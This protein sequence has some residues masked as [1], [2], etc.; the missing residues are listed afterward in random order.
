MSEAIR[1]TG[2]RG[3]REIPALEPLSIAVR[4]YAEPVNN[5][6]KPSQKNKHRDNYKRSNL[7]PSEH[8][9]VF[10]TETT[11]D[12]AQQLRFGCFQMRKAGQLV[13]HGL[14]YDPISLSDS[15]R[16]V[17]FAYAARNNLNVLTIEEFIEEVFYAY[18]YELRGL[19]VGFNLPF[20]ISRLA[21]YHNSARGDMRGGFTFRLSENGRCPNIQVKHLNSRTALI[22][23]AG[24][25][26]QLTPKGMRKREQKVPTRRG[27]FVDVRTLA[28][29]LLGGSWS[30]QRLGQHLGTEHRKLDTEEHGGELTEEYLEYALQD[31]LVTWVCYEKLKGQYESY[32]L[33]KTPLH[34]VYSEASLGK[35]YLKQMGIRPWREVQPDFPPD[36]IGIIMGTYYGGRSEVRIR[37]RVVRVLA[38]PAR[39]CSIIGLPPMVRPWGC[40]RTRRGVSL[41][42]VPCGARRGGL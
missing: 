25:A 6:N 23:F 42:P 35:A 40:S 33:T 36:L 26:G 29:A 19:C 41:R 30:L 10:D 5:G 11:T 38:V 13:E 32:G 1:G 39:L 18:V 34:K 2:R 16:S 31:V 17:L 14:F 9:L 21:I 7:K 4:A 37:R 12:A 3:M 15:E 24:V 22:R 28:G 27:Y 20:D 8:V